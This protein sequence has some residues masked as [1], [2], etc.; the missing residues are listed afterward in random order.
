MSSLSQGDLALAANVQATRYRAF[1]ITQDK[2]M[3]QS[4]QAADVIVPIMCLLA[5]LSTYME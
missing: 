2:R 3:G 5:S 1:L 4:L